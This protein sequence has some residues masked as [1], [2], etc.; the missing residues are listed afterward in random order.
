M[1]K[2]IYIIMLCCSHILLIVTSGFSVNTSFIRTIAPVN[3]KSI[4]GTCDLDRL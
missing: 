4:P 2:L 3:S 1:N